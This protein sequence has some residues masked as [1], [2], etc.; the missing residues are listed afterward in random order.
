[1]ETETPKTVIITGV[2]RG[3]GEAL[4][5]RFIEVG[6]MVWGC[7]RSQSAI[8]ALKARWGDPHCFESVDVSKG[9]QVQN[10]LDPLLRQ[11]GA[12]DLLLN[13]AGVINGNAP[14]WEISEDEFAHVLEVHLKLSLIHI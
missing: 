10:W 9:D 14:L 12:P 1:M 4:A 8:Q 3:L 2:T 6:H 7:G 11:L 5:G 13:N